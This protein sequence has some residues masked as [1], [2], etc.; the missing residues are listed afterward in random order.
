MLVNEMKKKLHINIRTNKYTH[1]YVNNGP[2]F[3][4]VFTMPDLAWSDFIAERRNAQ[5]RLMYGLILLH[6]WIST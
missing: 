6:L 1:I 2:G 4:Q 5:L 3:I